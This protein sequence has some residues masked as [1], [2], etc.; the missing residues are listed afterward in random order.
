MGRHIADHRT[1]SLGGRVKNFLR[2]ARG[3][4]APWHRA[5]AKP[6]GNRRLVQFMRI[7]RG[8]TA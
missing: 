4:R 1:P 3:N 7:A 6:D 8:R 5:E 2:I